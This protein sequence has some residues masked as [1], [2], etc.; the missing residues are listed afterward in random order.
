[1]TIRFSELHLRR[2]LS[3]TVPLTLLAVAAMFFLGFAVS[4]GSV[5][6]D[7]GSSVPSSPVGT[8]AQSGSEFSVS[9]DVDPFPPRA[10]HAAAFTIHV[11]DLQGTPVRGATVECDMTMPAMPMP[12]NRP[13]AVERDPG[14][15]VADVLFTMAGEWEANVKVSLPDGRAETFTFAMTTG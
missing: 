9:L 13:R 11:S 12:E 5:A 4:C 1:L 6:D 15:Y 7:A 3:G 14:T 2:T 10:M 8:L